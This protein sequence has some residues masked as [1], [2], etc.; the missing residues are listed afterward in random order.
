MAL[1]NPGQIPLDM[2]PPHHAQWKQCTGNATIE[3]SAHCL[4]IF[5]EDSSMTLSFRKKRCTCIEAQE[6]RLKYRRGPVTLLEDMSG[7]SA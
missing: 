5:T 7:L 3:N 2:H 6:H 4:F 1:T